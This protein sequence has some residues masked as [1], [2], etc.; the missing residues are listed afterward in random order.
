MDMVTITR[1]QYERDI[2]LAEASALRSAAGEMRRILISG[3]T[4]GMPSDEWLHEWADRIEERA[5]STPE[6]LEREDDEDLRP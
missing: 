5:T 2:A 1:S 4:L 6:D 3:K